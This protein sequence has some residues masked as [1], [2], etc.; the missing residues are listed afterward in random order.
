MVEN[1]PSVVYNDYCKI[2]RTNR[3]FD[4]LVMHEHAKFDN[5]EYLLHRNDEFISIDGCKETNLEWAK[6]KDEEI[7]T[8]LDGAGI[9]YTVISPWETDKVLLDLKMK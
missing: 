9:S 1:S 5:V 8:V 4:Q 3:G 2:L 7:K 6:V